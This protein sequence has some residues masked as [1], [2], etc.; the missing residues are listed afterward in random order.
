MDITAGTTSKITT[1]SA[2]PCT[3]SIGNVCSAA[4]S[5]KGGVVC[6]LPAC[7]GI[8]EGNDWNEWS[9][10]CAMISTYEVAKDKIVKIKK[11]SS[12][13]GELV[14][15]RGS[16]TSEITNNHFTVKGT[17]ELEDITLTGGH[18]VSSLCFFVLL[19]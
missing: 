2:N 15:D 12:M 18:G 7:P 3:A 14:I 9:A 5:D 13:S 8:V 11:S 10:S 4:S 6:S 16:I 19:L 1:C 17:L